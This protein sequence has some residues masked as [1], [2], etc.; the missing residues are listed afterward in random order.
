MSSAAQSNV[1]DVSGEIRG[2]SSLVPRLSS[3]FREREPGNEAKGTVVC[4]PYC[5]I[6]MGKTNAVITLKQI[7]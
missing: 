5:A 2:H 1:I 7:N 4:V 6:C 3:P